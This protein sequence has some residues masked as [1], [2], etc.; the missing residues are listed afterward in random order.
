[1]LRMFSK[2]DVRTKHLFVHN[3]NKLTSNEAAF[4]MC[5]YFVFVILSRFERI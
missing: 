4:L 2:S 3:V 5:V 1:M